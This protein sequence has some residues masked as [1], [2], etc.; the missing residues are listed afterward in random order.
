MR[1]NIILLLFILML[2]VG[3]RR[4]EIPIFY[5]SDMTRLQVGHVYDFKCW[6]NAGLA[7]QNKQYKGL[8]SIRYESCILWTEGKHIN[9]LFSK[10]CF[11]RKCHESVTF[12]SDCKQN[13]T[14]S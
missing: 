4:T 1:R 11:N 2:I 9:F 10:Y 5:N 6:Y 7:E 12:N 3:C 13:D 8:E 14:T